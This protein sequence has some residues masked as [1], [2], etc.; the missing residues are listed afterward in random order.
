MVD[1]LLNIL[2]WIV[3]M[4]INLL[5]ILGIIGYMYKVYKTFFKHPN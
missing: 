3:G 4:I 2:G 5:M 1:F